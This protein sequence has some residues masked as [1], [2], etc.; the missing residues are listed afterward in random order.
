MKIGRQLWP[1]DAQPRPAAGDRLVKTPPHYESQHRILRRRHSVYRGLR[2]AVLQC[3][4]IGLVGAARPRPHPHGRDWFLSA[5]LYCARQYRALGRRTRSFSPPSALGSPVSFL[6]G[7]MPSKTGN[8]RRLWERRAPARLADPKGRAGTRRSQVGDR[9]QLMVPP[10]IAAIRLHPAT[11][12]PTP[13]PVRAWRRV[14]RRPRH[15]SS[16]D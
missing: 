13:A 8:V 15:S 11:A 12:R 7:L 4:R 5:L 1:K 2:P 10:A 16:N 9:R 3:E 14:R 6:S